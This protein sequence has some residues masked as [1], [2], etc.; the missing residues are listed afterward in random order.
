LSDGVHGS[1]DIEFLET[2][3][4]NKYKLQIAILE[5]LQIRHDTFG[6]NNKE[7]TKTIFC[8]KNG[9]EIT[10]GTLIAKTSLVSKS[11]GQ[12]EKVTHSGQ[13]EKKILILREI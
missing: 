1:A 3:E 10:A 13:S 4:T 2:K 5:N 8:V 11:N 6:E 12:V 7:Q 9:E